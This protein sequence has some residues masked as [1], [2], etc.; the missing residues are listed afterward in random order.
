MGLDDPRFAHA[1]CGLAGLARIDGRSDHELVERAL[2]ALRNLEHRG[3]TGADPDTGD[4]AGI[5][6]AVA[7]R[8][9][10]PRLPVGDRRRAAAARPLRGR[11]GLPAPRSR[12][13]GCAARSCACASAPRRATARW[14]G[15]T[16]P[17]RPDAIGALAR[18]AQPFVRQ[19]FVERRGGDVDGFERK[20]YVIRRR[21]ELAAAAA[22]VPEAE[23][24][25]ISLSARRMVYK[26]LLKAGQLAAYYPDLADPAFTSRA[27]A[28]PLALLDEHA[29]HLG[30]RPSVQLPGPQRRD[31]HRARQ[32]QLAVGARAA[33]APASCSDATCR[34]CSRSPRSAGRTPPSW[35]PCSSCW[36]SAA[37]RCPTRWPCWCPPAWTDPTPGLDDEVRA[38][39]EYHAALVEPWDGPAA[40]LASDGRQVVA[41][42]DRNGLRPLR[43]E[44]TRDGLVGDRVGGRRRRRRPA[45]TWP[46]PAASARGRCS[47][48]T[49]GRASSA[50]I[51][52]S[53]CELARQAALPALAGRAQGVPRRPAACA[54][55]APIEADEAAPAARGVRLHRGGAGDR[56][57]DGRRA[58][59]SRSA[60][61]ATTRRWR[62]SRTGAGRS[63]PTSSSTSP[64]SRTRRSTRSARRW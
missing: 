56:R 51:A 14:A 37:A 58:A 2:L 26:G 35:M 16:C 36:C 18:A 45:R 11:H 52:K 28:R 40:L 48:S 61:W 6:T 12:R 8:P 17:V 25:F 21:V 27:R 24:I 62:R 7:R 9:A 50:A 30:S 42:L 63:P 39:Y 57:R 10:A 3:A 53:S 23:F 34:S 32:R 31:Q 22:G 15:A 59:P 54:T 4:G 64:R 44:R 13:C 33:A 55:A 49:R 38:F 60:R 20:L 5:L 47:S 1:A 41:A 43:Y 19:L 29:G 46:R